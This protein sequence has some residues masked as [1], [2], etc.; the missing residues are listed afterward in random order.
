MKAYYGT[1]LN[2]EKW[3]IPHN[4]GRR[5]AVEDISMDAVEDISL[6]V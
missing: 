2:S 6:N 3:R 5:N 1:S 4:K